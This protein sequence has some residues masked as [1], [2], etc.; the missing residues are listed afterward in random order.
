[1]TTS[2]ALSKRKGF[3]V[4][5]VGGGITGL[6][7]A[8]GLCR[9][10]VPVQIYEAAPQ[11]EEIG[12]GVSLG[13]NAVRALQR[14][15]P[16]MYDAFLRH[17]TGNGS[18]DRQGIFFDMRH[19]IGEPS[20]ITSVTTPGGRPHNVHRAHLLD[21]I[22]A[23]LPEAIAHFGKRL[24]S[25]DEKPGQRLTLRFADGSTAQADAVVGCDGIKSRV[26]HLILS[27]DSPS[28][29]A[30]FSGKFAYRGL[31]PMDRAVA[32][33]GEN[34]ARNSQGY[35]GPHG[36]ILTFP[37]G[38]GSH[39][40]VVAF[41]SSKDGRWENDKWVVPGS[42]ESV[43]SDFKDWGTPVQNIMKVS[44]NRRLIAQGAPEWGNG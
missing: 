13:P 30:Q 15:A 38:H 41:A 33:L 39:M 32:I 4:A 26:R 14:L 23:L 28:K 2:P 1:M 37:I 24:E 22:K 42:R 3:D 18:V 10:G 12:A 43:Q 44:V 5:I 8:V 20:L 27:P 6:A 31:I 9:Q 7:F 21:D 19:G 11:F 34:L 36:H 35:L 16:E 25:I 40:N 17:A 29:E